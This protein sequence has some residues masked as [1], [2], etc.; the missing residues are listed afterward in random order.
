FDWSNQIPL[1]AVP[2]AKNHYNQLFV[3]RGHNGFE[4][5]SQSSGILNLKQTESKYD[6]LPVIAWT[7]AMV[8]Y[9][10]D[11]DTDIIIASGQGA[12][13]RASRGGVNRSAIHIMQNDGTGHFTDVSD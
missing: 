4:D 5:V 12:Y 3:N 7:S 6:G 2:F 11:G 1:L 13:P 10:L 8:D 9:D